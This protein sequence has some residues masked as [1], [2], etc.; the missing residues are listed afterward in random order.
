MQTSDNYIEYLNEQIT[1][2]E[3]TLSE[4]KESDDSRE[5]VSIKSEINSLLKMREHYS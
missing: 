4:I 5:K 1:S 2:L 3:K